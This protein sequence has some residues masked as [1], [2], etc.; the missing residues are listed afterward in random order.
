MYHRP[1]DNRGP[2]SVEKY[3][4]KFSFLAWS[5]RF[6]TFVRTLTYSNVRVRTWLVTPVPITDPTRRFE[7][8]D[9][10]DLDSTSVKVVCVCVKPKIVLPYPPTIVSP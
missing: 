9:G 1:T 10:L 6:Y 5:G 4:V 3:K 2:P 7:L 8:K